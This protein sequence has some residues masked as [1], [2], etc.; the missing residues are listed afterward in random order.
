MIHSCRLVLGLL[1]AATAACGPSPFVQADER[2]P[3]LLLITV[4]TLRADHLGCYGYFRDTSPNI[5]RLSAE[6]LVFERCLSPI[7]QTTPSHTSLM[8]G[9]YP[10]EHGVLAN[11]PPNPKRSQLINAFRPSPNL[12]AF[13]QVARRRGYRTGGFVSAAPVKSIVGL[14]AGFETWDQPEEIFRDAQKTHVALFEWLREV[15][16]EPWF[17]WVHYWEPHMPKAASK[18]YK[19]LFSATDALHEYM[20]G[21]GF[22]GP[23]DT[24]SRESAIEQ[25]N[26]YD[27]SVRW[28]DDGVGDLF[29][30]LRS[31]GLWDR[32]VIVLTADHGQGLGQHGLMG[33][34]SMWEEQLRVPLLVAS[35]PRESRRV[36]GLLSTI[37][38]LPTAVSLIPELQD[39]SFA[40][41]SRGTNALASDHFVRTVFG[42]SP[43]LAY[44]LA[45]ER[46]KY[47]LSPR[48]VGELYDLDA[49]PAELTDVA[50]QYPDVA[51][52]MRAQLLTGIEGQKER[53]L[54]FEAGRVETDSL[55]TEDRRHL[56][57]LEALGYTVGEVDEDS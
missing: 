8:T 52:R 43:K 55:E 41:Q 1:L 27:G 12:E 53:G 48:G 57:E 32:T 19:T 39:E 42:Q 18:E 22:P 15:E 45:T 7:S 10:H 21:R 54:E 37:D 40:R 3:N 26:Q 2:P 14:S 13:A 50:E 38:I 29:D 24:I 16:G 47:V 17:A 4:D 28:L 36:R 34:G 30:E 51:E 20:A 9:V 11:S 5:D 35:V 25:L 44:C 49:D 33:H 31:L 23:D 56:E 46:W 6:A